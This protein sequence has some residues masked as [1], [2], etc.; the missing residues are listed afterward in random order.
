MAARW[1]GATSVHSQSEGAAALL[2][3]VGALCDAYPLLRV[4]VNFF[5][6]KP[7]GQEQLL[8]AVMHHPQ[9][10]G[11]SVPGMKT[12]FWKR[13]LTPER[14]AAFSLVW[15]FD[16]DI[17]VHPSLFPLGPLAATLFSLNVTLLQPAIR[18]LVHGTHHGWLRVRPTH[19]SCVVTTARWVEMQTPVFAVDAWSVVHTKMLSIVKD[20][21]LAHSD[22]GIDVIW[23]GLLADAFP[24]RPTC[25]VIP[26]ETAIH[27]NT[28]SIEKF[29]TKDVSGQ[30][31][32]LSK[33][34]EC[35]IRA[36]QHLLSPPCGRWP[37]R[38]GR[39]RR[40]A[41]HCL[42]HMSSIGKTSPTTMANVGEVV[43]T[44]L[45]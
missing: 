18:A 30:S 45:G 40:R 3:S 29:M 20:E 25:L 10:E 15:V 14:V 11:T 1:L 6:A 44:T 12:L 42:G 16:C 33:R 9:L 26:A 24:G 7:L 32:R 36:R 31:P 39:A 41:K 23:C 38:S 4:I 21:D 34:L 28:H 13:I 43:R 8:Q 22:Y 35:V 2:H 19:M 37:S 5:D 17:V 27:I